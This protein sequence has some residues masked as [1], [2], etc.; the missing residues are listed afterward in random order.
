MMTGRCVIYVFYICVI[1]DISGFHMLTQE[2]S[3]G[4]M[5]WKSGSKERLEQMFPTSTD[6]E[7][8][9]VEPFTESYHQYKREYVKYLSL[10]TKE[11]NLSKT[12]P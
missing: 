5:F 12:T 11:E 7:E 8:D 6:E 1:Y 4:V 3:H 2:L 10:N 9:G